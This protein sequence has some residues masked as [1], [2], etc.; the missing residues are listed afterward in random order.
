MY[1]NEAHGAQFGKNKV[2][3]YEE[4][5][6]SIKI[7]KQLEISKAV[8]KNRTSVWWSKKKTTKTDGGGK[9]EKN[10]RTNNK[11]ATNLMW[12]ANEPRVR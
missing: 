5:N 9:Y 12:I 10:K 2:E 1:I 6:K 4:N 8:R 3:R 11:A 7:F